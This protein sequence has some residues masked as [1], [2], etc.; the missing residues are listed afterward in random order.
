[1]PR[2]LPEET[3]SPL[4]YK[5]TQLMLYCGLRHAQ[6]KLLSVVVSDELNPEGSHS[7]EMYYETAL[8]GRIGFDRSRLLF[9]ANRRGVRRSSGIRR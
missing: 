3:L 9:V 6:R 7:G 2:Y 8:N 1:M 5:Q 4:Y